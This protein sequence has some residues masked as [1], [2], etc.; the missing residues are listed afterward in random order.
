[1][2]LHELTEAIA[3][4]ENTVCYIGGI[5]LPHSWYSVEGYNNILYMEH[6]NTVTTIPGYVVITIPPSNYTGANFAT[7]LQT[8]LQREFPTMSCA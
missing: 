2:I 4:P 5:S 6:A 8:E 1:M 3:L 7:A